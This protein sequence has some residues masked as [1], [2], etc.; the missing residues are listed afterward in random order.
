MLA[1]AI[2]AIDND[3]DRTLVESLYT[4]HYALM[5]ATAQTMV[6]T[7]QAAEDVVEAVMLRLIQRI[8]LMRGCNPASVRS[9]LMACVRNEAIDRM[10]KEKKFSSWEA[11]EN[12]VRSVSDD[13]PLPE[14][15]LIREDRIDAVARALLALGDRERLVLKMKYYDEMTEGEIARLLGVSRSG[16][17]YTISRARRRVGQMLR[18]EDWL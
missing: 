16:I 12:Q 8:D 15:R 10:R 5:L 18:E 13:A 11:A 2:A 6:R 3:D 4:T 7:R 1:I 14:E 17:H 9:Y